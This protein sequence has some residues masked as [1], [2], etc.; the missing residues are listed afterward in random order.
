M[1]KKVVATPTNLAS[2]ISNLMSVEQSHREDK[3]YSHSE[4]AFS[5][6]LS[7]FHAFSLAVFLTPSQLTERLED[8]N[9]RSTSHNTRRVP[10]LL[11]VLFSE[12]AISSTYFLSF[13]LLSF[14]GLKSEYTASLSG[15]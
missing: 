10:L 3:R 9:M 4:K 2:L 8:A 6:A 13:R 1:I 15:R 12:H 14:P 5:L 11:K 7:F